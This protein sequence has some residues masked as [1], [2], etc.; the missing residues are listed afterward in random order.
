MPFRNF[1][2]LEQIVAYNI[3]SIL[4]DEQ[5]LTMSDASANRLARIIVRTQEQAADALLTER[6]TKNFI[7]RSLERYFTTT[8]LHA[9]EIKK[10]SAFWYALFLFR[11]FYI[12]Q[13]GP[14]IVLVNKKSKLHKLAR[15]YNNY[16]KAKLYAHK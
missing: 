3:K 6:N 2:K 1:T 15:K 5:S 9:S 11:R 10:H 16:R 13:L 8:N 7:F 12:L 4:L 14:V